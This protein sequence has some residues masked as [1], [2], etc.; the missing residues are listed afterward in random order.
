MRRA[1]NTAD[2]HGYYREIGVRPDASERQIR[3]AV[4]DLFYRL[5]PD[6]GSGEVD[7]LARVKNVA[8]VLLNPASRELYNRTP[9][10]RR[11]LD[12]V[13]A[14]EL[15][16]IE[17]LHGMSEEEVTQTLRPRPAR[18]PIGTH[19]DYLA[20]HHDDKDSHRAAA[21]YAALVTVAPLARYR[22]V[23]KVLLCDAD[24]AGWI[25]AAAILVIPRR[26]EPSTALAFGVF[27][28]VAGCTV[29]RTH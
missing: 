12:A 10:G 2:P 27:V 28:A 4:R 13:Y 8:E 21:W 16:R 24:E 5:H 9:P 15:S 1:P 20:D 25:P 7:R 22:R 14:A 17:H 6:T 29:Y 23:V 3:S 26:W 19:Y 18:T 11:L